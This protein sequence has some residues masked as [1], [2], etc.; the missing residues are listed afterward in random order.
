MPFA[1]LLWRRLLHSWRA[2]RRIQLLRRWYR[3]SL[4]AVLVVLAELAEQMVAQEEVV[5]VVLVL[6]WWW[7]LPATR[8]YAALERFWRHE[9]SL[10]W[11]CA[12]TAFALSAPLHSTSYAVM[13]RV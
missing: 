8:C 7:R 9:G 3:A 10:K 6:A 4:L 12:P 13:T 11:K 5:V 2:R 1:R